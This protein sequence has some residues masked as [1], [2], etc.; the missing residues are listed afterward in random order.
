MRQ[1][2]SVCQARA[3]S[4]PKRSSQTVCEA[5]SRQVERRL[6]RE[7]AHLHAAVGVD[8]E[9]DLPGA[10]GVDLLEREAGTRL[11]RAHVRGRVLE[12]RALRRVLE[13]QRQ[14]LAAAGA[15]ASPSR[16]APQ[17]TRAFSRP[18]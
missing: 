8:R 17:S 18:S 6:A 7:L 9:G 11:E 3:R 16:L 12:L 10:A 15:A 4:A 14:Q 1:A 2:T 13:L 5:S